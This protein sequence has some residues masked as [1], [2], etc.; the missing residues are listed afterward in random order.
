LIQDS[1][2]II[3]IGNKFNRN[4]YHAKELAGLFGNYGGKSEAE[5]ENEGSDPGGS[6]TAT[7][8]VRRRVLHRRHR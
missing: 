5:E 7:T 8:V 4:I 6:S 3:I 1:A 2:T